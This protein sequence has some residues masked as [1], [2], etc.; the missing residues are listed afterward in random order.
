[1]LLYFDNCCLNRPYDEQLQLRVYLETLAKLSVQ[2]SIL[3]GKNSLAWSYI[4][5]Y[6]IARNPFV[7][8]RERFQ[9]WRNIARRYCDE[10][11]TILQKAEEL[12]QTGLKVADSLH[13]ACAVKMGCD[14]LLTTDDG[15]LAR[16][17]HEIAVFNPLEFISKELPA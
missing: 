5:D 2:Q 9:Q 12:R 6:E 14:C 7:E 11:E 16:H 1:M 13:S 10:D 15:I 4:L 8:R 3:A 17:I